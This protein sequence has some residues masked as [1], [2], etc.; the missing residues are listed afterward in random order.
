[1]ILCHVSYIGLN[2]LP[3]AKREYVSTSNHDGA[4][5][6][7]DQS[8]DSHVSARPEEERLLP[9]AAEGN[10]PPISPHG[11]QDVTIRNLSKVQ[12]T[13]LY[14][15]YFADYFLMYGV[16]SSI[17][18]YSATAYGQNLY[19]LIVPIREIVKVVGFLLFLLKPIYSFSLVA[20][21]FFLGSM[22]G[23]YCLAIAKLSPHPPLQGLLIGKILLV[24]KTF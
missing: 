3:C 5:M 15:M 13:F 10:E 6:S 7:R 23:F 2:T 14:I 16:F 18:S 4:T 11:T 8:T 12:F 1:M 20:I 19:R 9:I 22:G 24:S 21:T 17:Q